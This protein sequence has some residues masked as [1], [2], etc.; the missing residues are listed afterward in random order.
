MNQLKKYSN[1]D[2]LYFIKTFIDQCKKVSEKI[3]ES[4]MPVTKEQRLLHQLFEYKKH[5]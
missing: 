4:A 5:Q 1:D 2:Q 3:N